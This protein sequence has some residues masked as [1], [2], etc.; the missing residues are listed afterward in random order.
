MASKNLLFYFV[1]FIFL[2]FLFP[3]L[4]C[5]LPQ[6][7]EMIL[8]SKRLVYRGQPDGI[9]V[10]FMCS[11]LV[12]W[13][14]QVLIPGADLAPL[15]KPCCGGI[16]GKKMEEDWHRCQLSNNLPQAERGRLA[17]DVGLWLILL[18]HTQKDWSSIILVLT[19]LQI[20]VLKRS[21]LKCG[22]AVIH[23][24]TYVLTSVYTKLI[25][26][27]TRISREQL[28]SVCARNQCSRWIRCLIVAPNGC[29]MKDRLKLSEWSEFT[30]FPISCLAGK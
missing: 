18:T 7:L 30:T 3:H 13:G 12:A 28:V 26:T 4:K 17:T 11:A 10:E 22:Q 20:R 21:Y 15:I 5:L 19:T 6:N 8:F 27:L 29:K 1:Y 25:D 23:I 2:S 14:S 16:P 24:S 9:V